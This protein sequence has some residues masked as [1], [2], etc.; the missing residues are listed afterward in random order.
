MTKKIKIVILFSCKMSTT[1]IA[2]PLMFIT[3]YLTSLLPSIKNLSQ[4]P[5]C[6]PKVRWR[7]IFSGIFIQ[8]VMGI[9]AI[10]WSTGRQAVKC[11][12]NLT[13][14]FLEFAYVGASVVFG[15]KLVIQDAV[16]AFKV[17]LLHIDMYIFI[18]FI[19]LICLYRKYVMI[20]YT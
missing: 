4:R 3:N 15:E 14:T 9:L 17:T 11:I 12:G 2:R 5:F 19:C 20:S 8:F 18:S 6:V 16:F 10:R 13:E 7:I 1:S